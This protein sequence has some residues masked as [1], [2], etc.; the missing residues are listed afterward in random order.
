[1]TTILKDIAPQIAQLPKRK[2]FTIIVI[3]V[4]LLAT[5]TSL[6][7][8]LFFLDTSKLAPLQI[9]IIAPFS[10]D[11]AALGRAMREGVELKVNEINRNGGINGRK[12]VIANFDDLN[13]PER[14]K[15][16]AQEAANSG[17]IA[18]IAHT[19]R[20][21][22]TAAAPIYREQKIG[23]ITLAADQNQ[24]GVTDHPTE[25]HL[26]PAEDYEIRFLAN[27]VRNVIGE[28]TV[29]II[30]ENSPTGEL[31]ANTLDENMQRF[32]TKVL[33][34][35]TITPGDVAL[36]DQVIS[37]A[38]QINDGKLPGTIAIIA[39]PTATARTLIHLR[40]SGV[41][42]PI[43]GTRT[44][45]TNLFL[46]TLRREWQGNTSIDGAL[47]GALLTVPMLFDVSGEAAQSF[48]TAFITQFKHAPDWVAA[49]AHDAAHLIV[50][51]LRTNIFTSGITDDKLREILFHEL[52][53]S[54]PESKATAA[55]KP[56]LEGLNGPIL[57]NARGRDIRPPWMGV[58][59][60]LTLISTMT[61]LVAI[62][63]EGVG[64]LLQQFIE[65]RALYV[66]DR[67]MYKTNVIYTGIS[68]ANISAFN[69]KE[70]T[71]DSDFFIWFRWRG[72]FKPE[73]IVFTN[74]ANNIQIKLEQEEKNKEI[75]Y[76][77]YHIQGKFY[78]NFS[79]VSRAFDTKLIGVNFHH[80]LLSRHNVMYVNDILGMGMTQNT[81]V[82][83]LLEVNPNII[84]DQ[85]E[86]I[87]GII[88]RWIRVLGKVLHSDMNLTDPLVDVLS[89]SNM[90]A[91][92]PG[93]VI[94][95]AWISQD[96]VP[97]SSQGN[98]NYVGFGKPIPDFS[99]IQYG[100]ILKPDL[101]RARDI[102]PSKYFWYIA[103]F[104]IFGAVLAS[105]LDRK[106]GKQFWRFHTFFI[107]LICWPLLLVSGG[108]LIL[109]YVVRYSSAGVVD[110][111]WT[112]YSIS[113]WLIPT[114]LI[115][116]GI[117]RFIWA[118][119]EEKTQR[120]IPNIIRMLTSALVFLL[121][122]FG[123]ISYVF[124][125]PVT[126]LLA[127]TGLSAMIIGFAVKSNIANVFSGIVLNL[128]KP[129]AIGD[130]IEFLFLKKEISGKVI[131]ITWRTT[132]IEHALGHIVAVPNGKISELAIHNLSMTNTGFLCDLLVYVDPQASPDK[133]LALI[134]GA[135]TGNP[136]IL[137]RPGTPPFS[138]VLLGMRNI[139]DNW[140]TLYRVRIYVKGSPDGKP[141]CIKAGDLFWKQL[142]KS[143][144]AEGII[145][146][147]P[148]LL[149]T[150]KCG[151]GEE[152]TNPT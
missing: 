137:E 57:V 71:I 113:H 17:A 21:T 136:H 87:V 66:N 91:G 115:I 120:K 1:M 37:V 36:K 81:T 65:G 105:V 10:G 116:I 128:E 110:N 18:V 26:L 89:R 13:Q 79:N 127:T 49:Y 76:R 8:D 147:Q 106:Y 61:Q 141:V 54:W 98:P 152:T 129:F 20:N 145:W 27:Y 12:L 112:M 126:N 85:E 60:G 83:K 29:H 67:F 84:Q 11:E 14:A 118:P 75:N 135:I 7:A 6:L 52:A 100:I 78:M 143:F 53:E 32:G 124:N 15:I 62:R 149:I 23:V 121:M 56:P 22:L 97:Q 146:N 72:D 34:R 114:F 117:D 31:L 96:I 122:L 88:V 40:M 101:I 134:K 28:K 70:S 133:V 103:I 25:S 148:P 46:E 58:Y 51:H 41:R 144:A 123:I 59:D 4:I 43:I 95:N 50:R 64:N 3:A 92:V 86:G 132:K 151:D 68:A 131:D 107:R 73:D 109:D 2:L 39:D 82:Q 119:L 45:A 77:L 48:R 108:N 139:G 125:Q 111:V 102:I 33:Y 30:H 94:D 9:A 16:A 150:D 90:L 142:L 140:R 63:E 47:N 74:A 38:Q 130:K 24:S 42:N 93:W 69:E 55:A 104:A 138:V 80:R 5:F 35:W 44:M 99:Q 19:N